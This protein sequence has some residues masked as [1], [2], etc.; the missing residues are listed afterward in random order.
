MAIADTGCTKDEP[1]CSTVLLVVTAILTGVDGVLQAGGV[2][3][4][5]E[6]AFLPTSSA[7]RPRAPRSAS[8]S[9]RPVPILAGK[10]G[11]GLGLVGTF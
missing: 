6:S 8:P 5:I 3:I 1:D 4:A 9:I 11:I 10:D 7:P 2:G